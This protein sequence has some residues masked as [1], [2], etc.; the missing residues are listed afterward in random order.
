MLNS[1][2]IWIAAGTTSGDV[3]VFDELVHA[4]VHDG[5]R[6][7]RADRTIPFC[8]NSVSDLRRVLEEVI[9]GTEGFQQGT[10]NV[11]VAVESIYSMDGDLAP[12]QEIVDVIEEVLG[13]DRGYVVV[14]EA[15]STGVLG[16]QGRGLVCELGLEQRI[17]A[18]LHTFGKAL[19]GNGGMFTIINL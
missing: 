11:I 1:V 2:H 6:L 16:A 5:M 15:H 7:S 19:A 3:I 18:R 8:H 17:F 9:R 12:L 4:S 13:Q 10:S 14:D